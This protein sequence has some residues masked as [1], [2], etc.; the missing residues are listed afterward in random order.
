MADLS[1]TLSSEILRLAGNLSRKNLLRALGLLESFAHIH[2]H[3]RG[4]SAVREMIEE[5]HPGIEAAQRILRQANPRARAAVLNNL[6][7]GCLLKGYKKRLAFYN[8]HGTAPPGTLMISPTLRCNLK[9][10]GCYAGTHE[11]RGELTF[12]EVDRVLLDAFDMGTNFIVVLGGEP[13]MVP[14]LLDIV[15]KHPALAFQIYTNG[16]LLDDVKIDRLARMGNAAV[17]LSV[18][19][20]REETDKRRGAGTFDKVLKVMDALNRAGVIVGYSVMASRYNFDAIYSDSFVDTLIEHGAGYGWIPV[21]VPQGYACNEP[22]LIPTPE[23]KQQIRGRIQALRR[24][25]PIL[26]M[27]FLNDADLTEGCGAAR[28]TIHVNANG[29]VEPCVLMPFAVDNIRE[30]P[31]KEIIRSDFFKGLRSVRDR[32]RMETQTCMWVYKP[33][34]VLRTI[35]DCGARATSEGVMARLRELAENET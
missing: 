23:Q 22:E 35:Q 5:G 11:R 7:L 16:L 2:W 34:E 21:A 25:K 28:I 3:H 30:K 13:F 10:Y 17:T 1:G 32:H 12:D 14:W 19:G 9:C 8:E 24:R 33:G 27:D 26:L 20:L 18:D 15:E 6:I 4:F 29:D 31:L